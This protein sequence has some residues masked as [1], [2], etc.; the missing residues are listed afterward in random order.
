MGILPNAVAAATVAYSV[1]LIG[2]VPARGGK[3]GK[4]TVLRG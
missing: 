1:Q 3:P 2:Y 4:P